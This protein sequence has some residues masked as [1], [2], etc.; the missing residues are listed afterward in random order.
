LDPRASPP[1][2]GAVAPNGPA[3]PEVRPHVES[4][5]LLK[6]SPG[7]RE[8]PFGIVDSHRRRSETA[9]RRRPSDAAT[10]KSDA[11]RRPLRLSPRFRYGGIPGGD[12]PT[13]GYDSPERPP[14]AT[15]SDPLC[16]E[17]NARRQVNG[18]LDGHSDRHVDG[19]VDGQP[20]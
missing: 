8:G 3:G 13:P 11:V 1:R 16:V 15:T 9:E 6:W 2:A 20:V 7:P 5:W 4:L 12:H 17:P 18:H 19:P 14:R 10:E